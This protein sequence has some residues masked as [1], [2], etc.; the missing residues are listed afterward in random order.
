MESNQPEWDAQT[1]AEA[2]VI[3]ADQSR[4]EA[5]KAA[6]AKLAAKKAEEQRAMNKVA[7]RKTQQKQQ[8]ETFIPGGI[9]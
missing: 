8:T 4:M 7:G 9:L 1:L 5:A 6:A 2:E 3:K